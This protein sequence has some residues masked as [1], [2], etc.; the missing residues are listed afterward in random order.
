VNG[1][2]GFNPDNYSDPNNEGW[3]SGFGYNCNPT[4]ASYTKLDYPVRYDGIY[5]TINGATAV[6]QQDCD[7]GCAGAGYVWPNATLT[8]GEDGCP[9]G[10]DLGE[11]VFSCSP[12]PYEYACNPMF[13]DWG[14]TEEEVCQKARRFLNDHEPDIQF[15]PCVENPL[16]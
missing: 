10:I 8:F 16:P 13:G 4:G 5:V 11:P 6:V 12:I 7:T 14:G 15:R 2:W 3:G 1:K 9:T